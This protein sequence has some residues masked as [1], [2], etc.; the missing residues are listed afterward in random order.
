[1][2]IILDQKQLEALEVAT[3][4]M[5]QFR[6]AFGRD[7]RPDF[8]AELYAAREL[9]LVV[10]ERPNE[11]GYDAIGPDG[12]RYE[13]KYRSAQNVD[14]NNFDFDYL[15]LVNLDDDYRLTGMW[16]IPCEVAR[17]IFQYREKFNKYQVTQDKLKAHAQRI[18]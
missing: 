15:I 12:K 11:P 2:P 7:L 10:S 18:R 1:M 13:I 8:I 4:A 6:R 5:A 16:R 17:Q 14:V 9:A 3:A